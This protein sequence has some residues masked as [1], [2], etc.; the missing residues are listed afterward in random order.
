MIDL[1]GVA[2]VAIKVCIWRIEWRQKGVDRFKM[3][4]AASDPLLIRN[5]S[6]FGAYV[7]VSIILEY[8]TNIEGNNSILIS[9]S[10]QSF[11]IG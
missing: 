10:I 11:V 1:A 7:K 8:N 6:L 3:Q 9:G 5:A 2:A 4:D